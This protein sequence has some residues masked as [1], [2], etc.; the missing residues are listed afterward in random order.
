MDR[1]SLPFRLDGPLLADELGRTWSHAS[2]LR[3][4][5]DTEPVGKAA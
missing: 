1:M 3:N 5:A 4:G 2:A